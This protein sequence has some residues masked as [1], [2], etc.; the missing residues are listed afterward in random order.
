MPVTPFGGLFGGS[1]M[2]GN[3]EEQGENDK[4]IEKEEA[5]NTR[6]TATILWLSLGVIF[7]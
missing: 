3:K 5:E 1:K 6:K 4:D 2:A 7:N